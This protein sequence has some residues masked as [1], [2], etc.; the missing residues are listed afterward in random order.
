MT[1]RPVQRPADGAW[2]QAAHDQGQ[3]RL[4]P[5][6]WRLPGPQP[7]R[8][9][10]SG[11]RRAAPGRSRRRSGTRRGRGSASDPADGVND[12]DRDQRRQDQPAQRRAATD[13]SG[14][15]QSSERRPGRVN[16]RA[17]RVMLRSS[18]SAMEPSTTGA[19]MGS[20]PR[21]RLRKL[22]LGVEAA[23][24]LRGD[25][26]GGALGHGPARSGPTR[27]PRTR[28]AATRLAA[29]GRGPARKAASSGRTASQSL[30]WRRSA[31]GSR[32]RTRGLP[33]SR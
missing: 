30:K 26:R 6:R 17:S 10:A 7:R 11:R 23:S 24:A 18:T 14:G 25:D 28:C 2:G 8:R 12:D 1:I 27:W 16:A 29:P 15:D 13:E 32:W 9:P 19:T 4:C 5:T 21:A 31:R 20:T 22:A 33:P 3:R